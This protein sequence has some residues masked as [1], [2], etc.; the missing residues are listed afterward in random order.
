[1]SEYGFLL[2]V[3]VEALVMDGKDAEAGYSSAISIEPLLVIL[4]D[5]GIYLGKNRQAIEAFLRGID[6]SFGKN[7]VWRN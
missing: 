1:L 2:G 4:H 3:L 6:N 5:N 7:S